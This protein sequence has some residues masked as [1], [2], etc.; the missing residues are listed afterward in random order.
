V[1]YKWAIIVLVLLFLQ[2]SP[3]LSP[4]KFVAQ[5]SEPATHLL[6]GALVTIGFLV[7]GLLLTWLINRGERLSSGMLFID[8]SPPAH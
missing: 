8:Q 3:W 7:P 2:M 6:H 1:P 5:L 4:M